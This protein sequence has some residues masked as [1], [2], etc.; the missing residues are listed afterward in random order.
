MSLRI[1]LIGLVIVFC[2]QVFG[3]SRPL[4]SGIVSLTVKDLGVRDS[5]KKLLKKSNLTYK[6]HKDVPNDKLV[7]VDVKGAKWGD[8]FRY[9]ISDADLAYRFDSEGTLIIDISR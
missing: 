7:S 2:G 1:L 4:P 9:I 6:I 5:I 3:R 8:V